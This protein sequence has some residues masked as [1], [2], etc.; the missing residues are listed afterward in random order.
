MS[1]D[2][3]TVDQIRDRNRKSSHIKVKRTYNVMVACPICKKVD[4]MNDKTIGCLCRYCGKYF[5]TEDGKKQYDSGDVIT[6]MKSSGGPLV[7]GDK[8]D[9]FKFRDEHEIR[10]DLFSQ[11]KTRESM[12]YTAFNSLLKRE[13]VKN[14]AYR[15]S[16]ECGV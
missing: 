2:S 7:R 5:S 1:L 8:P 11:G 9:Y 12:G 15:G 14:K 4:L 3:E 6:E 13:L 16:K 10:A